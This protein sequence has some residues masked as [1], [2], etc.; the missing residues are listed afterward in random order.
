[1]A[2]SMDTVNENNPE[3][4]YHYYNSTERRE[5]LEKHMG[6]IILSCYDKL[7]PNAYKADLF[8][9]SVVYTYGGC[10]F[11]IG[12]IFVN[13]LRDSILPN[14]TFISTPDAMPPKLAV[15]SAFFCAQAN[16]SILLQT[17]KAIVKRVAN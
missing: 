5:F 1:M 6:P 10:Y 3:Y 15:N 13:S 8:R 11:D 14:D 7:I 9:Y 12:F 2:M 17:I 4:E 16:S